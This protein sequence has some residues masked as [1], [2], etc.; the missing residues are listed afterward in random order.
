MRCFPKNTALQE[1][2]SAIGDVTWE[3]INLSLL[4]SARQARVENAEMLWIDC[5]VTD[6]PIHEPSNSALSWDGVR[7]LVRLLEESEELAVEPGVIQYWNHRRRAKKRAREILY[8]RGKEKKTALYKDLIEVTRKTLQ[9]VEQAD[10]ALACSGTAEPLAFHV[11]GR[12]PPL[13]T[14]GTAGD[15]S[16]P[17]ARI[18]RREG[19]CRRED[20]QPVRGT[21]R[22]HCQ[23]KQEIT[24]AILS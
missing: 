24:P 7:V 19:P 13:Q 20:F 5:T 15:R 9:Y 4:D 18:S 14:I 16:N 8:T 21:Y 17:T 23:S 2:I 3:R 22:H 11:A 10:V 6:S 1:T 12:V